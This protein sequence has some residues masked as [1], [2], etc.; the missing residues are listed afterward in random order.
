MNVYIWGKTSKLS[1]ERDF[2]DTSTKGLPCRISLFG[3]NLFWSELI[4]ILGNVNMFLVQVLI[5]VEF[6]EKES[7]EGKDI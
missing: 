2:S 5:K 3:F 6:V 1:F 7:G 4:S